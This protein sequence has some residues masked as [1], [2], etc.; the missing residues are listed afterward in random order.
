MTTVLNKSKDQF[1]KAKMTICPRCKGFGRNYGDEENCFLC[2]GYNSIWKSVENTGWTR[3]LYSR[4][5]SSQL[6]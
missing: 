6:Y 4:T 5:N 2:K 3:A 1:E